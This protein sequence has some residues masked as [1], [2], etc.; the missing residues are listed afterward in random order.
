MR[1]RQK[2]APALL[3][4]YDSHRRDLPWRAPPGAR[5]DPYAVW[6][7]EIML[8]QTTV[9]TV[10]GYFERFLTRW[11][12]VEAL[13]AAPLEEAL[14]AWAGL[15]YYARARN[16]HACAGAVARDHG[17]RFPSTEAAL[18][19]LP[20]VGPYTAAAV[21]AIAFDQPCAAVD[22]NVERVVTRLYAIG[23]PA[24]RAKPLIREKV[25]AMMPAARA[26][27][28]AQALMDL[29]ATVCTPRAPGC[30]ACPWS[31]DCAARAAGTQEA[32]PVKEKKAEKPKR[33]GGIFILERGEETLL[34]RRPEKGLFGGMSAFP[35]TP[36]TRDVA[37][38]EQLAFAPCA[39]DWRALPEPVSHVFTHFA[40]TATV[41]TARTKS[42]KAPGANCRWA[43][44]ANLDREG[45]PTL[46]RKAALLAGLI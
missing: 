12:T 27:D 18:L 29:G 9:A 8:Q 23:T 22:G 46:M 44:R 33:R 11:P 14:A 5:V 20:G 34:S 42:P 10:K 4:W 21:A 37:P 19:A 6:L 36:F 3:R 38:D 26:G 17:G 25:E 45:L 13:A 41:F 16:L 39:A 24:R 2:L 32:Y 1:Q 31:A 43:S 15:G 30:G 40:L 28:F 7:S 35:S